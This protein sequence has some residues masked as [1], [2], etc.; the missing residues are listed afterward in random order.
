MRSDAEAR[1]LARAEALFDREHHAGQA[2][3]IFRRYHSVDAQ[4]G[5]ALTTWQGPSSLGAVTED[6]RR[7]R[8]RSRGAPQPRLGRL[9]GRPQRRRRGG[10][11][12]DRAA[13]FPDSPYG[14]DAEDALHGGPPGLPPIVTGLALP[15]SIANLPAA[16]QVAALRRAAAGRD[17]QAKLLYGTV[18]WN[19]LAHADLGRA[20]VRGRRAP[21]SAQRGG[22]RGRGRRALLE[23]EPDARLRAARPAH[24]SLPALGRDRVPPRRA[25]RS[26]PASSGRRRS[27][28]AR[29]SR[30]ARIHPTCKTQGH[31]LASMAH[32]RSK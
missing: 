29:P 4:L 16:A 23:G 6:R 2:A 19:G 5:L 20:A 8:E 22:A 1:A 28:S 24:C 25:S 13:R 27:N 11:A 32:T 15:K 14:V 26:T 10:L 9:P 7:A 31:L 21:R 18:L 3:A 17:A 30:T 12:P